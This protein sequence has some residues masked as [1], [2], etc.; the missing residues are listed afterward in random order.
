MKFAR[1]A[2]GLIGLLSLQA[3]MGLNVHAESPAK[4]QLPLEGASLYFYTDLEGDMAQLGDISNRIYREFI[5]QQDGMPPFPVDVAKLYQRLGLTNI[6]GLSAASYPRKE[7]Y[8]HNASLMHLVESKPVGLW[9]IFDFEDRPF[10]AAATFSAK[11]DVVVQFHLHPANLLRLV[12]TIITDLMG[13]FGQMMIHQYLDMQLSE[14]GLTVRDVV[15]SFDQPISIA[16]YLPSASLAYDPDQDSFIDTPA[17]L[18][19]AIRFPRAG[20]KLRKVIPFAQQY[21]ARVYEVDAITWVDLQM[22]LNDNSTPLFGIDGETGDLIVASAAEDWA[23]FREGPKLVQ[24]AQFLEIREKLPKAAAMFSY[25]STHFGQSRIADWMGGHGALPPALAEELDQMLSPYLRQ[26]MS[27]TR[28][29]DG[30]IRSDNFQP[31]SYKHQFWL[32]GFLIIQTAMEQIS[33]S[34]GDATHYPY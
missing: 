8:F 22:D 25:T 9:S 34:D 10:E 18:A 6:Q 26:S 27:T 17:E 14:D 4:T 15:L 30:G 32:M 29:A 20:T 5:L 23:W 12:E 28:L 1:V 21:D 11:S 16:A 2:T 31:Y 33:L 13:P 7:G 24:D 19:F 3:F